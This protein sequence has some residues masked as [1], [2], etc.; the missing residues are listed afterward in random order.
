MMVVAEIDQND[1]NRVKIGQRAT[2]SSGIFPENLQGRVYKIG[3]LIGKN[4]ILDTDPAA[5]ED[6]RV[7]EVVILLDS[8]ASKRVAKLTNLEVDVTIEL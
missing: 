4:D 2:I 7:V 1:I 8:P 5:K 3:S 6:T